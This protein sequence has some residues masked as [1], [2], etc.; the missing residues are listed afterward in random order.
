MRRL[1][2]PDSRG[3]ARRA[4]RHDPR[5]Q[6]LR[7]RHQPYLLWRRRSRRI[8]RRSPKTRRRWSTYQWQRSVDGGTTFT[9][10]VDGMLNGAQYS[11]VTTAT[12][13]VS[14]IQPQFLAGATFRCLVSNPGGSVTSAAATFK[15][16]R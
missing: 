16:Q 13:T 7:V 4:A 15:V 6:L 10:L 14:G 11:G 12:L 1:H 2:E 9:N 8:R 3:V 5:R